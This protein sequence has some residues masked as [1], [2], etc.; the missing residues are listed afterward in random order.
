M[1]VCVHKTNGVDATRLFWHFIN[2]RATHDIVCIV[3]MLQLYNAPRTWPC[4][5]FILYFSLL[6]FWRI[7]MNIEIHFSVCIS[8]L[9]NC[10]YRV[11][12]QVFGWKIYI[13]KHDDDDHAMF[14]HFF[15]FSFNFVI[16][17]SI[18]DA[19]THSV[20]QNFVIIHLMAWHNQISNIIQYSSFLRRYI[21]SG[22][23]KHSY[24]ETNI[25]MGIHSP[26]LS[27]SFSFFCFLIICSRFLDIAH[28]YTQ[29][30]VRSFFLVILRRT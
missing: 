26:F 10:V 2:T 14:V 29:K 13:S 23:R 20:R 28:T 9:H 27:F 5:D 12:N 3:L 15:H 19:F 18:K 6:S 25:S 22:H 30:N 24:Q 11:Q 21:C 17:Q 4:T 7:K 8:Q 1:C 16:D